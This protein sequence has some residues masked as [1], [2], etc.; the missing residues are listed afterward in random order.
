M[1]TMNLFLMQ[2]D[3]SLENNET[4]ITDPLSFGKKISQTQQG[5]I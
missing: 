4:Y 2:S 1:K 5:S 3:L